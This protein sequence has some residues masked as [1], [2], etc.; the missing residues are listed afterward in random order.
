MATLLSC[1]VDRERLQHKLKHLPIHNVF[2]S[3]CAHHASLG[4]WHSPAWPVL[5]HLA[6]R[7]ARKLLKKPVTLSR[8]K[9]NEEKSTKRRKEERKEIKERER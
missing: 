9:R 3:L 1:I 8:K 5:S 6:M 2:L 4:L 7:V